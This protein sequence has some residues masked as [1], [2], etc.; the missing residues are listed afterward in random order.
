M[1][2]A[3]MLYRVNKALVLQYIHLVKIKGQAPIKLLYPM[4]RSKLF[5]SRKKEQCHYELRNSDKANG[6]NTWNDA[7]IT[8]HQPP[9]N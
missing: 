1:L 6:F 3:T 2:N 5:I 8:N 9:P 7:A 4:L